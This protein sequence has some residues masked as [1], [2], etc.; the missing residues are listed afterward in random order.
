[1]TMA[2]WQAAVPPE[3]G[4]HVLIIGVGKYE[5]DRQVFLSGAV[6]SAVRAAS[7][8]AKAGDKLLDGR[9]L[10]S[11]Q[12][13]IS[14]PDN[15]MVEMPDGS[16][17]YPN[18]PTR[19]AVVDAFTTWLDLAT[20]NEGDLAVLHWIGHGAMPGISGFSK[21][22]ALYCYDIDT[23]TGDNSAINWLPTLNKI[24]EQLQDRAM[25]FIDACRSPY[26]AHRWPRWKGVWEDAFEGG[27]ARA[28]VYY[29]A[30]E[31]RPAYTVDADH[32][33]EIEPP[34]QRKRMRGRFTGG[35][36][37]TEAMLCV[38]DGLGAISRNPDIGHAV[39]EDQVCH[40]L[41]HK[42][43]E[44]VACHRQKLGGKEIKPQGA[45]PAIWHNRALLKAPV[46]SASIKLSLPN[47]NTAAHFQFQLEVDTVPQERPCACD[48]CWH[49]DVDY[50]HREIVARVRHHAI[51]G[52]RIFHRSFHADRLNHEVT[53][54]GE[55][56]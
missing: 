40:I 18:L 37:F 23:A 47:G 53:L 25:C 7:W 43:T 20:A 51:R 39:Y 54:Q 19:E 26:P 2:I 46:P 14:G 22:H 34:E 48:G 6:R 56:P 33:G 50:G 32:P 44:W 31:N 27:L 1:M 12:V 9:E 35:A 36:V 17:G 21:S 41:D 49:I 45:V 10:A 38:L 5:N 42:L 13:L 15:L 29:S 4:V 3:K 16:V 24:D 8:W 28:Y 11:I 30:D 55:A 52:D